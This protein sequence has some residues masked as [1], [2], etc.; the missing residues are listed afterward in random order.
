MQAFEVDGAYMK[1]IRALQDSLQKKI[2]DMGIAIECNPTSNYLIG[3]LQRYD[4]HPIFRF[5]SFGLGEKDADGQLSVSINTDDQGVFD[6][7]LE[8]EYALLACCMAKARY[9]DNSRRYSRDDV[10]QYLEHIRQMGQEQSFYTTH[11]S[12]N[13]E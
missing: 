5:N 6:T 11:R 3:T 10:Y 4:E 7:S 1:L 12:K 8:N 2:G 13:E 9:P